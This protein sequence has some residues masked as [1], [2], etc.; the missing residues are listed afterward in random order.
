MEVLAYGSNVEGYGCIPRYGYIKLNTVPVWQASWCGRFPQY[1][2]VN[3]VLVDPFNCSVQESRRFDTWVDTNGATELSNYLKQMKRGSIVVGVTADEP[4][5]FLAD[6]LRA[7]RELG[8]DVANV[9]HRGSF[10]FVAQKCFPDKTVL[11]KVL[12]E[13]E[14]NANPP[15]FKATVTGTIY[16]KTRILASVSAPNVDKWALSADIRFRPKS[17]V[18][19][20]VHFRFRRAAV[21]KFGGCR[22]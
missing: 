4:S 19:H 21:G 14:S 17:V 3:T 20:S 9:Q 18:P 6:A 5:R 12:T 7:L 10:G 1:R 13:A 15:H 16:C 22:K 2:G 8:V 11:R